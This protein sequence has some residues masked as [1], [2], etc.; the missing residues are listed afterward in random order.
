M[1]DTPTFSR[2]NFSAQADASAT[3][4]MHVSAIT[5][6]TGF[7]VRVTKVFRNQFGHSARLAHRLVFQ[8][9]AYAT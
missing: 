3:P 2:R 4:P 5:V 8:G 6:A 1:S 7:A 9:L